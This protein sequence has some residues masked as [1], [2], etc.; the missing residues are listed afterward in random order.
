MNSDLRSQLPTPW[1]AHPNQPGQTQGLMGRQV[2][3]GLEGSKWTLGRGPM[4]PA[5]P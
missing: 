4:D 1:L 5:T 3:K 2:F